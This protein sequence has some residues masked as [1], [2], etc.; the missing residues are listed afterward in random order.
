MTDPFD[1]A[2]DS[3][4]VGLPT[5]SAVI[6]T[7]NRP[8]L[9]ASCITHLLDQRPPLG[10]VIVVDTSPDDASQRACDTFGAAVTYVRSPFGRGTTATSRN[11]GV[12]RCS[13]DIVLFVDDDAMA[14]PDWLEQMLAPFDDPAVVGVGGRVSNGQPGEESEGINQIGRLLP[15]QTLTGNFAANP[16]R[17]IEVD[18]LLGASMAFR[19]ST[20]K[21]QGGIH[22][23]YPGPCLREETDIALR[24]KRDGGRLMFTPFAVV[25][26]LG[27]PYAKGRRF[28]L[29]Y[30]YYTQR[31]HVVLLRAT[32]GWRSVFRYALTWAS[33]ASARFVRAAG[34]QGRVT[35]AL[36]GAMVGNS[37]GFVGLVV[38]MV[39]RPQRGRPRT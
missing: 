11:L 37:Y 12:K 14:H 4:A 30:Q 19:R 22:D 28:D 24:A 38:G 16:G 33:A 3:G 23:L 36:G 39:V 1:V 5:T 9:L 6:A 32:V 15:D 35:R 21:A 13:G 25:D 34:D 20:L 8:E 26:H 2:D 18:H 7:Y 10:E 31:N 27:G 17:V 29:R